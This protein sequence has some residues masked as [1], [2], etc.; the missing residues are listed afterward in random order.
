M[1]QCSMSCRTK[2]A[3]HVKVVGDSLHRADCPGRGAFLTREGTC[4]HKVSRLVKAQART[5]QGPQV[6]ITVTKISPQACS[7]NI[8][9]LR[10]RSRCRCILVTR[11]LEARGPREVCPF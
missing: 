3:T 1:M 10:Y 9:S 7:G 4:Q 5:S 11:L 2:L 8:A 6:Q